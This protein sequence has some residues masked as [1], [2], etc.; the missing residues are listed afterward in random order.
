MKYAI[1]LQVWNA[2]KQEYSWVTLT[3]KDDFFSAK[4]FA[5]SYEKNNP[6]TVVTIYTRG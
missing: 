4:D 5:T 2:H 3:L 1:Q 6:G